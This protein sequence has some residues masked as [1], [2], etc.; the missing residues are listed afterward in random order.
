MTELMTLMIVSDFKN[1][2]QRDTSLCLCAFV[3]RLLLYLIAEN[4]RLYGLSAW[5]ML[6]VICYVVTWNYFQ[7]ITTYYHDTSTSWTHFVIFAAFTV[8]V[9]LNLA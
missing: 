5:L 2:L 8:S 3:I 1:V 4:Q 9:T 6:C 7:C